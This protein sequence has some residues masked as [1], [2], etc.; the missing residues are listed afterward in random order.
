MQRPSQECKIRFRDF[1]LRQRVRRYLILLLVAQAIFF[2]GYR[3]SAW[4]TRWRIRD[5]GGETI[6]GVLPFYNVLAYN[7]VPQ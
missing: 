1:T 7:L 6:T 5:L 3:A 2:V 4:Y